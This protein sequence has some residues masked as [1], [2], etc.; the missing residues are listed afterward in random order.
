MLS[1]ALVST[2]S[3]VILTHYLPRALVYGELQAIHSESISRAKTGDLEF[4]AIST[5][6]VND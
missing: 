5:N 4:R 3:F 2:N 1:S 6:S